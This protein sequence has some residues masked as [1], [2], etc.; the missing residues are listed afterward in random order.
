ML[1]ELSTWYCLCSRMQDEV[2]I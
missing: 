2:T 1:I